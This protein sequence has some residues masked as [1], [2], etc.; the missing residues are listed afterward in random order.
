MADAPW[1]WPSAESDMPECGECRERELY[2]AGQGVFLG[3]RRVAIELSTLGCSV[4]A[5]QRP[6]VT[7]IKVPV[8]Y[9]D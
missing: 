7:S 3:A 6:P 2:A 4:V 8:T 1:W 9:E 5:I